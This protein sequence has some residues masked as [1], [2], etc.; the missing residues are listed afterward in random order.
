MLY[1]IVGVTRQIARKRQAGLGSYTSQVVPPGNEAPLE[2]SG[3]YRQPL[4]DNQVVSA[5]LSKGLTNCSPD[6]SLRGFIEFHF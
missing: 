3:F 5:Y 4:S 1:G 2:I 6:F